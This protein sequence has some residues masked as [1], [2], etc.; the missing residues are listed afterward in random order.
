MLTPLRDGGRCFARV[1][2]LGL[3]V[4]QLAGRDPALATEAVAA[5]VVREAAAAGVRVCALWGGLPG[6]AVWDFREGPTTLGLVPAAYRRERIAAL[7]RWA[8]FARW[9]G[10]PAVI[11][12]CGFIPE[13]L[14][15]HAYPP[16]VEA[17]GEV[18][19]HCA[20]RGVGFW[21]ETGQETPI[22]L[23]RTI[24]RVGAAN[25]GINLDPANLLMYG[26]G[27]PLDALE[28]LGP[29]VRNVHVKDGLLPTDGERLGREVPPGAGRVDY[30]RFLATL[31]QLG[32]TGELIIEREI[33]GAAQARDIR[34]TI[35]DLRG[36]LAG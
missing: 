17:I 4:C 8:D 16:V 3:G 9:I 36:W 12:H 33:G 1:R 13:N 2:R 7:K 11:T 18:A 20:A 25:L 6:P 29:Y 34:R 32:F 27:N 5:T 23:L 31:Q 26:K 15:D 35:G 21:F 10:A 24:A 14:T 19:A 22:V 28:M 30:P